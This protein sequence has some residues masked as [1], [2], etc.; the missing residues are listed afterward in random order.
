M[1]LFIRRNFTKLSY[2]LCS[3]LSA[4]IRMRNSVKYHIQI[5]RDSDI[6]INWDET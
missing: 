1:V 2:R 6:I 3:N 4:M 5:Y